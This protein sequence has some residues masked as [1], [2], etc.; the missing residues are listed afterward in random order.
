MSR[1]RL[2]QWTLDETVA[3]VE[4]CEPSH[5]RRR[6]LDLLAALRGVNIARSHLRAPGVNDGPQDG[7]ERQFTQLEWI[8]A[9]LEQSLDP[10]LGTLLPGLRGRLPIRGDSGAD[11]GS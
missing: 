3:A 9:D 8:K 7:F 11:N 4:A 5:V 10:L 2:R 6:A 1:N